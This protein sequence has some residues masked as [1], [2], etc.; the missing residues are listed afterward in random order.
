MK[1]LA[2]LL[3]RLVGASGFEPP[4]SCSRNSGLIS[5][6]AFPFNTSIEN[7]PDSSDFRLCLTVSEY[8]HLIAGSLQ[9]SL[10]SAD[11]PKGA[12]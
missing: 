3:K 8:R 12:A 5:R 2:N 11:S 9:K 10:Q 7:K 1:A 6:K 4:T